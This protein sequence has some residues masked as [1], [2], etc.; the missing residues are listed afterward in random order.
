MSSGGSSPEYLGTATMASA[1]RELKLG[2]GA[3][4]PV[5]SRGKAGLGVKPL[6]KLLT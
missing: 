6:A 4:H 1:V 5:G 3:V 2:L